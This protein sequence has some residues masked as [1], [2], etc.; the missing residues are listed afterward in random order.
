[1][2]SC[3][4][5]VNPLCN[6]SKLPLYPSLMIEKTAFGRRHGSGSLQQF[7][8][9]GRPKEPRLEIY[10]RLRRNRVSLVGLHFRQSSSLFFPRNV[11]PKSIDRGPPLLNVY[12]AELVLVVYFPILVGWG[13]WTR[14]DHPSHMKQSGSCFVAGSIHVFL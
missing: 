6:L 1:M 7:N 9:C 11:I 8:G 13:A 12:S 5:S 2:V 4:L 10:S 3:F 14:L